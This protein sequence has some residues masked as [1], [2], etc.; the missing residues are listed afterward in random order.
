MPNKNFF[1]SAYDYIV[2]CNGESIYRNCLKFS[3]GDIEPDPKQTEAFNIEPLPRDQRTGNDLDDLA[4]AF[5][6]T[7]DNYPIKLAFSSSNFRRL[8]TT[9]DE[10]L[11]GETYVFKIYGFDTYTENFFGFTVTFSDF[12]VMR[13]TVVSSN[14]ILWEHKMGWE[15]LPG[16]VTSKDAVDLEDQ[17]HDKFVCFAFTPPKR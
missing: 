12:H 7:V 15:R 16:E 9:D 11:D 10:L 8:T 2:A 14:Q 1:P 3:L 13:G 6:Y 4:Q 5:L 17:Y